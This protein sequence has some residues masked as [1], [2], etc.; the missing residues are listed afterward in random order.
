MLLLWAGDYS[1]KV[2][3]TVGLFVGGLWIGVAFTLRERVVRPVQT[4]SNLLAALLEGDYS[5]R[6]RAARSDDALGLAMREL[7]SLGETLREQR[8]GALE[9]S[10]LLRKVMEEIDVAIFTFDDEHRLRLVNRAGER[11]MSRPAERI[12]GVGADELGLEG[13]LTGGTHRTEE[14]TFAG[15]VGRYELRRTTFRQGGKPHQLL[16]LT[17]LS[18]TLR[19]EERQ[20]WKRLIRVLSHEINN[21]L[22]PIKSIAGSLR[23][24]IEREEKPEDLEEDLRAGL[25]VIAGRSESLGRFMG[26]YARLA[27]L[28]APTRAPLEVGQWIRRVARLEQ[29]LPVQV[30]DG[31]DLV[32]RADGDQL[33]QLLINLVRNAVDA[34]AETGGGVAVSWGRRDGVVEVRVDDEG[35]GLPETTN[36]FV[37]FFTTKPNGSGIGLALS[38]QI[39]E[40]H[41]GS[42]VLENRA[43]GQGCRAVLRLPVEA[44]VVRSG[45]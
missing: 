32:I 45:G 30:Q 1:P 35:P 36:L 28:P 25:N 38:R 44:A 9:A 13:C 2:Q 8:M 23:A 20:A 15:G 14:A 40:A 17:D 37:P 27:R 29:R 22:A 5:I 43:E 21:S 6:S 11:L 26:A 41:G 7:N 19:E 3:W 4:F 24:L 31:P 34:A 42:L 33:D 39:A 12:L 10:R 16:V 18:H